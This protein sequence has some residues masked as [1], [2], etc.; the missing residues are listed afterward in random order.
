MIIRKLI[1]TGILKQ[2]Y[3]KINGNFPRF[4]TVLYDLI[5][6]IMIFSISLFCSWSWSIMVNHVKKYYKKFSTI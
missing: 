4:S 6:V 5:A 3:L 2:I 1:S